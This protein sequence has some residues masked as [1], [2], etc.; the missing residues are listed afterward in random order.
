MKDD[1]FT[2]FANAINLP[3]RRPQRATGETGH[4]DEHGVNDNQ[5]TSNQGTPAMDD[6][7]PEQSS[8]ALSEP[9]LSKRGHIP[10]K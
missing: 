3:V 1:E 10:K 6:V 8:N 9:R 4:L 7:K 5:D 2:A